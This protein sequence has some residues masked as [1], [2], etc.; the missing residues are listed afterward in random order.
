MKHIRSMDIMGLKVRVV[1]GDPGK[2]NIGEYCPDTHTITI[3]KDL[4][5]D[6][7]EY[8]HTI[9]HEATHALLIR[10]GIHHSAL[11]SLGHEIICDAVANMVLENWAKLKN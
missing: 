8:L 2:G 11:P 1:R 10:I 5:P 9:L 6:S 4:D 7:E 3:S